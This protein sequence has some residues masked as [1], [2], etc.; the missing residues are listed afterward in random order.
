[1]ARDPQV[2]TGCFMRGPEDVGDFG[3]QRQSHAAVTCNFG[4][5]NVDEGLPG[6]EGAGVLVDVGCRLEQTTKKTGN[7]PASNETTLVALMGG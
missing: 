5:R 1:M 2:H 7:K 3:R 4:P 6:E